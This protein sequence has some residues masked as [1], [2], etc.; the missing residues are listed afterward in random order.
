MSGQ[1]LDIDAACPPV[2]LFV[3]FDCPR[4][5]GSGRVVRDC[6]QFTSVGVI[7]WV[8]PLWGVSAK[9]MFS[10]TVGL[11]AHAHARVTT[12]HLGQGILIVGRN[13]RLIVVVRNFR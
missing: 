12:R 6:C 13:A 5:A 3:L 4:H 9:K 1:R 8:Q 2:V 10:S 7:C 11:N